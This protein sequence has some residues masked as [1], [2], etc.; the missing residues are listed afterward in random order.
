M[1][2]KKI[3]RIRKTG[4]DHSGGN[5]SWAI[6]ELCGCSWAEDSCCCQTPLLGTN[7]QAEHRR[8]HFVT[9]GG[10][11]YLVAR[12]NSSLY[13]SLMIEFLLSTS[14]NCLEFTGKQCCLKKLSKS[15]VP[16]SSLQEYK[17]TANSEALSRKR[18]NRNLSRRVCSASALPADIA[19][20]L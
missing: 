12:W 16:S 5:K 20:L 11:A 2:D 17:L 18:T 6:S 7:V 10:T 1:K 8:D 14:P 4:T 19:S 3:E 13:M 15:G 9:H